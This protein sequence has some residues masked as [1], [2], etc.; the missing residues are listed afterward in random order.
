[1]RRA[2][3]HHFLRLAV[4]LLGFALAGTAAADNELRLRIIGEL[5]AG[6]ELRNAKLVTRDE[7]ADLIFVSAD[8]M[9]LTAGGEIAAQKVTP[10]ALQPVID[11]WNAVAAL[12][13]MAEANPLDLGVEPEGAYHK[14]GTRVAFRSA[15]LAQPN[16]IVFNLSSAGEVQFLYP[17]DG[18]MPSVP[19]GSRYELPLRV[20]AP[21]GAD[22]LV[23]IA[24]E[25]PLPALAR[26]LGNA[27][28]RDV[29]RIV[30]EALSDTPHQIGIAG[31]FASEN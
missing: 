18:D 2:R 21:P 10:P 8:G 4:L 9:L 25:K 1:M 31:L 26:Q 17:Q 13:A 19:K 14:I 6:Q 24:S 3:I 23:V 22:H 15:P 27:S 20:G 5:P 7:P 11:K 30:S 16:I 29:A 12:A 28:A